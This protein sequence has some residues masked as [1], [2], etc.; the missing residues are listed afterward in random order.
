MVI[1]TSTLFWNHVFEFHS[2]SCTG[3]MSLLHYCWTEE[4]SVIPMLD[5]RGKSSSRLTHICGQLFQVWRASSGPLSSVSCVISSSFLRQRQRSKKES[6][7]W[8][9]FGGLGSELV[10]TSTLCWPSEFRAS[11][12]SPAIYLNLNPNANSAPS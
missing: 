2:Q 8:K 5:Q 6:R 7:E 1:P 12:G 3:L 9:V 11:P 10:I 4:N